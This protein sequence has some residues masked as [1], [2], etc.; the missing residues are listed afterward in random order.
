MKT[1]RIEHASDADQRLDKFLKKYLSHIP[2]GGI[3]RMLRTGKI[4]VNSRR[5]KE[6]YRLQID[7]EIQLFFDTDEGVATPS[8][9]M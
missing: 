7:D 6:T 4:K 8:S 1:V 2:L 3:Y 5:A 9:P